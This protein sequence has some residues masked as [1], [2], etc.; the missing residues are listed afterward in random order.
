MDSVAKHMQVHRFS[1]TFLIRLLVKLYT[2]GGRNFK[3]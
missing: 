1:L 3:H 2:K